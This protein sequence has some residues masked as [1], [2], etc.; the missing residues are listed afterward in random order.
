MKKLQ[1]ASAIVVL[2]LLL[3]SSVKAERAA[4]QLCLKPTIANFHPTLSFNALLG[5]KPF[6]LCNEPDFTKTRL[7][8]TICWWNNLD[9]SFGHFYSLRAT[10]LTLRARSI[11]DQCKKKYILRTDRRPTDLTFGKISNGHISARGRPIHF[12]FGSTVG[13]S[14]SADRMGYFRFCQIQDGSST[15][16]LENSNGDISVVD[17]PMYS[18]FGSRMGFTGSADRMALFPVSPNPRWRLGRHL[19]KFKWRYLCA[20]HSIYSRVWF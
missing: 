12:M 16:I 9:A 8:W 18:V 20:D 6:K 1:S 10:F 3:I 5:V 7:F 11:W 14:G 15:A 19:G 2:L 13:F 4:W 17:H